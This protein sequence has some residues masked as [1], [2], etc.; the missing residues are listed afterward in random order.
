MS[1]RRLIST[2][3][4]TVLSTASLV[5]A[6]PKKAPVPAK[7]PAPL[8]AAAGGG[9]GGAGSGSAAA[10]G[11]AAGSAVQPIED[12]PPADMNGTDEN[13]DN[14]HAVGME[15]KVE[16]AA[17]TVKKPTGYPIEEALRPITL[18]AN[19]SEIS[20]SPH[21]QLS[22]YFGGDAIHAR[23]GITPK[24]QIGLT[25]VFASIYDRQ[26]VDPGLS[27]KYGL[28]SGKAFGLDVTVLLQNWLAVRVGVP[29]YIDPLAFSLQLG[30]PIKFTF[31][32][33]YAIGGLDDLLNITLDKFA[34]SLY[35]DVYNAIGAQNETNGTQQSRGHLRFSA[36]GIY[37]QSPRLALI[38]R[39]GLDNDL[40]LGGGG[41]AGTSSGGGSATFIRAGLQYGVRRYFDLGASL[42]WDDLSTLGSFGPAGYLALRI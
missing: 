17:P 36:Y 37:Q 25:Y 13:P 35:Q 21:A 27:S 29:F 19:M 31:G 11:D 9:A 16:A 30:A 32:D 40:G 24:V 2:L 23:Y 5:A 39:I 10:G 38:G 4:V 22:P 7:E 3:G 6:A 18:P 8:P 34:P 1:L 12:T 28:H 42:G 15:T 26:M 20:I 33:K 14:P 41:G